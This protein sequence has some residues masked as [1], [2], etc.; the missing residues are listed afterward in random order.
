VQAQGGA[1]EV[2]FIGYR[3]KIAQVT[4]FNAGQGGHGGANAW[5]E[6]HDSKTPPAPSA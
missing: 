1:G 4:K 6:R 5:R 2:E 3:Q